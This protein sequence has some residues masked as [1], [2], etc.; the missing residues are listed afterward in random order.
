M[1]LVPH[2]LAGCANRPRWSG[3]KR[4]PRL[5]RVLHHERGALFH[6]QRHEQSWSLGL[7]EP[8][9]E[10]A[11]SRTGMAPHALVYRRQRWARCLGRCAE[12][13]HR[14]GRIAA[15]ERRL[16]V[17]H[18][19]RACGSPSQMLVPAGSLKSMTQL[20]PHDVGRYEARLPP[21]CLSEQCRS[22]KSNCGGAAAELA[23]SW[24]EMKA[25][26]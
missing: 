4:C 22:K 12:F 11:S 1:R 7:P 3:A 23:S 26:Y 9:A 15:T 2:L 6:R 14:L 16:V 10:L 17:E 20:L 25:R 13:V 5:K 21:F 19:R 18:N 24:C 8:G